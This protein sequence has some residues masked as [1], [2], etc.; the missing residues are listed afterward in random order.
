MTTTI[1]ELISQIRNQVKVV[2]QDNLYISD[3]LVF[4]LI[5]KHSGLFL[6]REDGN[7]KLTKIDFI[8]SSI[9]IPLIE[10]DKVEAQC[11][12]IKS[13]C[14]IKRTEEKLPELLKGYSAPLIRNITSIDMTQEVQMTGSSQYTKKI[15]ASDFKYNKTLYSWYL[16]GYLYFPNLEW[17]MI[18][19]EGV[20]LENLDN[21]G[22]IDPCRNMQDNELSIPDYLLSTIQLEVLKDLQILFQLPTD[23]IQDKQ[24]PT[25]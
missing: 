12:G 18:R 17:D 6:M 16:N 4:S 24:A 5:K 7:M 2:N 25:R 23:P 14:I 15:N 1:G 22:E 20:F 10:V 19:I 13:G 9:T 3:R 8:Y 11:T 21:C